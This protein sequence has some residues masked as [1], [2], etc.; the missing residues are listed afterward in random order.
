MKAKERLGY[1]TQKPLALLGRIIAASS[2]PGDVVLDPFCGCG[3]SIAA[4]HQLGRRWVGIDI[5]QVAIGIIRHRMESQFGLTRD[6]DY[7]VG[8]E[9][10]SLYE[11]A[12][13]AA[14]NPFQFQ[15]WA[16]NTLAG[17]PVEQK[18]GKDRGIDGKLYFHEGRDTHTVII[19]VKSGAVKPA[20]VRDLRGVI[21]REGAAI[22]VFV[23]L[24]EPT[25]DMRT[26]AATAG[27]YRSSFYGPREFPRLQIIP[28]AK[29]FTD[30][31]RIRMPAIAENVT[32]PPVT[33]AT[34]AGR[35]KVSSPSLFDGEEGE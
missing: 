1:P 33:R 30:E 25:K 28:V 11:A 18:K 7:T 34:P 24:H 22:G 21:E 23:T 6:R 10:T 8:G 15:A 29:M 5:T 16:V 27:Y 9:P 26:E 17:R 20:D 12:T 13:L 19:S 3:T 2:N 32:L 4:A 31:L 35:K 14:E